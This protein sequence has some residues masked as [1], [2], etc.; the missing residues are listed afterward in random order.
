MTDAWVAGSRAWAWQGSDNPWRDGSITATPYAA[1]LRLD[2]PLRSTA[3][4]AACL[5]GLI[6]GTIDAIATDHSPRSRADREVEFG[7]SATGMAGLETA[8]SLVLAAVHGAGLPLA[9]AVGALTI[10]PARVLGSASGGAATAAGLIVGSRANL[11]VFDRSGTWTPDVRTIRS[12][13]APSPLAGRQLPGSVLLTIAQ[14][15][16]AWEAAEA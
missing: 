6:D 8:L 16:L 13:G 15:R 10:G 5:Q 7:A 1:A 14:G 3:D 9:R 12:L 11:V 4:A 2:P